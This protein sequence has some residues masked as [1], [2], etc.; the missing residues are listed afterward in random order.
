MRITLVE[1]EKVTS[2]YAKYVEIFN[3]Y[4][5]NVITNLEITKILHDNFNWDSIKNTIAKYK[6]SPGTVKIKENMDSI[7]NSM[8]R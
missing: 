5:G 3:E 8:F 6:D 1:K 4:F 2:E 7:D